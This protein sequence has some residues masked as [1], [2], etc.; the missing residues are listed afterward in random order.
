MLFRRRHIDDRRSLDLIISQ[1]PA[2]HRLPTSDAKDR[3]HDIAVSELFDDS[4][5]GEPGRDRFLPTLR[6]DAVVDGK[7]LA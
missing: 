1:L 5:V 4:V 6:W 7:G 2:S 3:A